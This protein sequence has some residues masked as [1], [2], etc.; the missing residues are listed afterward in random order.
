MGNC[1]TSCFL[2][3][4]FIDYY[5]KKSDDSIKTLYPCMIRTNNPALIAGVNHATTL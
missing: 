4:G 1:L 3:I 2:F 5:I